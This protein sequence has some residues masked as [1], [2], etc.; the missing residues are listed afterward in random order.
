M[1]DFIVSK[2]C[3]KL[4]EGM[5]L[6]QT[7]VDYLEKMIKR[8]KVERRIEFLKEQ[9]DRIVSD[10]TCHAISRNSRLIIRTATIPELHG[11]INEAMAEALRKFDVVSSVAVDYVRCSA[12][13]Y[14][15]QGV[16]EEIMRLEEWLKK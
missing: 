9:I 12:Y 2:V 16:K 4:G 1:D 14:E 10:E 5:D 7:E 13:S 15:Y 11:E 6:L 3:E 8:R